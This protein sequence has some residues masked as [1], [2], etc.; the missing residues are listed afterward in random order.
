ME[1]QD[2]LDR[3]KSIISND[4]LHMHSFSVP[5]NF[6]LH[7]CKYKEYIFKKKRYAKVWIFRHKN[8]ETLAQGCP[9]CGSRAVTAL[10]L[11]LLGSL[12]DLDI[13]YA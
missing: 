13:S 10:W 2:T 8:H 12:H 4:R 6:T 11:I 3:I 5:V 7:K 1:R 9:K